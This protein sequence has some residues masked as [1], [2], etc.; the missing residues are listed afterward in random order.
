MPAAAA[1]PVAFIS[2]IALQAILLNLL[3][4]V[5]QVTFWGVLAG[6]LAVAAV[7]S[8][9]IVLQS[10]R[11][12]AKVWLTPMTGLRQALASPVFL[13]LAPLLIIS[14]HIAFLVGVPNTY[15]SL[16]YHMARV[17]HWMQQQSVAYYPTNISRQNQ[18]SPGAE[19]AILFF[20]ILT[21][22]DRLAVIPQFASYLL[23]AL[24]LGYLLRV[25]QVPKKLIPALVL[26]AM[27]TPM[28]VLQATTTQNDL[29]CSLAV[30]VIL[31][32]LRPFLHRHP[33]K[34]GGGDY[35]LLGMTLAVGYLVKPTSLLF[36]LPFFGAVM[37]WQWRRLHL[38][39]FDFRQLGRM[40][41]C[42][43]FA[44]AVAGPDIFRKIAHHVQRQEVYPL[45][46]EWDGD[47]LLNPVRT[48]G[49]NLPWPE[50]TAQI[51]GWFGY[52]GAVITNNV[53]EVTQD[54]I[55]NPVQILVLL[56]FSLLSV[57]FGWSCLADGR[58]RLSF[59]LLAL[60]PLASWCCF[61]LLVRNQLWITRLQLPVFFLT[62][63]SFVY[64]GLLLRK[65]RR[66]VP[67]VQFG[68]MGLALFSLAYASYAAVHNKSRSL[69]LAMFWGGRVEPRE[70]G[71]YNNVP[72]KDQ[73]DFFI[74]KAVSL[75][76]DRIGL[77]F[78]EDSVD[79]PLTWQ[80]MKL[81]KKAHHVFPGGVNSWPCL[82]YVAEGGREHVPGQG[83][84][85]LS[86][87]DYHTWIRNAQFE[88]ERSRQSCTKLGGAWS[89]HIRF[90][91]DLN[92]RQSTD[93]LEML[94]TGPDPF[95]E[96]PLSPCSATSAVVIHI[97]LWSSVE[98]PAQIYYVPADAGGYAERFSQSQDLKQ[99]VNDLY[100][101]L[102]ADALRRPVRFD[103]G[104]QPGKYLLYSIEARSIQDEG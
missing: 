50:Q 38:F 15:D 86:A 80:L 70:I 29:V 10:S 3:S 49:Q 99:G 36:V 40:L 95:M 57:L 23:I 21:G 73:H 103:P 69:D 78:G 64:L 30:V 17:A 34:V 58:R 97:R 71:Y 75:N 55:G 9:Y 93:G 96:V 60:C 68:L 37:V 14:F 25:G 91:Q 11:P 74:A 51:L 4:L 1:W 42:L 43:A 62:V 67:Y 6:N 94:A 90:N 5:Q 12:F 98:T 63:L 101:L 31:I 39:L 32:A 48:L 66:L 89:A 8:I 41:V 59:L 56:A 19:Y 72:I 76:C 53:F 54:F 77:M 16:T 61:A 88:F 7:A 44:L 100:F 33:A 20:Q 84:Q 2:F 13:L 65:Q 82:I 26:I 47:R 83:S 18:M 81:G 85:W 46:T 45:L 92:S 24:G 28:A 102:P 79:Y 22:S 104:K 35:A 27:T 87:G 52:H